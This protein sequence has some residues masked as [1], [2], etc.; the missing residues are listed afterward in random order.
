MIK[1]FIQLAFDRIKLRFDGNIGVD[2]PY[3]KK[4]AYSNKYKNKPI[5]KKS[6]KIKIL[7][8]AHCFSDSPHGHGKHLFA[9][10]YDWIDFLGKLSN[11]TITI[12]I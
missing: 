8:A 2:M 5:I 4:S 9:D 6:S 7:I 1:E 3:S 12:G 11:N 10:F